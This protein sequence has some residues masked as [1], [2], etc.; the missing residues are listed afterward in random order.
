MLYWFQDTP[1][2]EVEVDKQMQLRNS[3]LD[4]LKEKSERA[5]QTMKK[6][7]DAHRCDVHFA[8][9][10]LVLLKLRSLPAEILGQK[11]Q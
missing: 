2:L 10:D 9:G 1:S 7:T 8:P 4:E 5:Q 3:M 11:V 6:F